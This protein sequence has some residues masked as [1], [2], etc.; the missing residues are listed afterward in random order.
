MVNPFGAGVADDKLVHAYV[1]EM[2]RF[3][4][5]EEPLIESV[6]TSTWATPQV[7]ASGAGLAC[8]RAGGQAPRSAYGGEG[9]V[10]CPHAS[11]GG[12]ASGSRERVAAEPE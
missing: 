9:V 11:L 8:A 5:G 4:L 2:V 6:P 3:Y 12:R 10:I 1:E 7:R